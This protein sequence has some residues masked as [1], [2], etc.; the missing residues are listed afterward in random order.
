MNIQNFP[1]FSQPKAL[2]SPE[3]KPSAE[4]PEAKKAG[5]DSDFLEVFAGATLTGLACGLGANAM[6][7]GWGS[8]VNV[9]VATAAWSGYGYATADKNGYE[10]LAGLAGGIAGLT[11][12]L[13]GSVGAAV[14]SMAGHPIIGGVVGGAIAGAVLGKNS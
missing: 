12:G 2:K 9:P 1:K 5:S 14:G 6:G 7:A 8:L 10:G 4:K 11:F 13:A 3:Q